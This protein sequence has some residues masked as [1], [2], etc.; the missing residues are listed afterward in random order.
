MVKSDWKIFFFLKQVFHETLM[1]QNTYQQSREIGPY[2][3]CMGSP[4]GRSKNNNWKSEQDIIKTDKKMET[5]C[6][7]L[8]EV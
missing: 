3:C 1:S 7:S 2:V 5:W 4:N 6:A 8:V